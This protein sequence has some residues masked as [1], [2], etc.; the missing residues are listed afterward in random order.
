M[1]YDMMGYGMMSY[2]GGFYALVYFALA[3]FVFS[4]IFWWTHN[5][6]VVGNK[7]RR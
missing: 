3:A 5:W 4:V 6:L 2:F 1:V 7:R